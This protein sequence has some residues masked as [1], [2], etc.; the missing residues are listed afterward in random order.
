MKDLQ[1]RRRIKQEMVGSVGI[2]AVL[3]VAVYGQ[4]NNDNSRGLTSVISPVTARTTSLPALKTFDGDPVYDVLPP[5]AIAAIDQ[6]QFVAGDKA[7]IASD[8]PV[9]GVSIGGEHHA[10]SLRLLNAHEIVND[11]VGGKPV[12]TTW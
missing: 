10:Y 5:D 8:A 1:M 7:E 2:V 4:K 3:A 6:P 12:G 11:V 9:I